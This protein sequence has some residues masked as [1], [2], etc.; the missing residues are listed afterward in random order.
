MENQDIRKLLI[1]NLVERYDIYFFTH[2]ANIREVGFYGVS[3]PN[4]DHHDHYL[5]LKPEA[6]LQNAIDYCTGLYENPEIYTWDTVNEP[7]KVSLD[8]HGLPL[9]N[10]RLHEVKLSETINKIYSIE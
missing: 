9:T 7:V 8:T 6:T 2:T 5:Y 3:V 10:G 1:V 4:G